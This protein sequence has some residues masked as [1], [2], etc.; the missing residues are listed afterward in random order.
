MS[1]P[2]DPRALLLQKLKEKIESAVDDPWFFPSRGTVKGFMGTGPIVIVSRRPSQGTFADEGANGL[3]Y[4]ILAKFG[5]EDSHLTNFVKSRGSKGEPDP[6]NLNVH[7]QFFADELERIGQPYLVVPMG[8]DAKDPV[9][10]FLITR[11]TQPYAL[12]PSYAAM[13]YGDDNIDRKSTRLNSS[14]LGISYAV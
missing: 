13:W 1:L 3:F 6:S 14:H 11:G 5:L 7:K 12:L 9:S 10:A 2:V 8:G 4:E